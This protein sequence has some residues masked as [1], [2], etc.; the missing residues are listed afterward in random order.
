MTEPSSDLAVAVSIISSCL[1]EN[2]H[3]KTAFIGEIGM[4]LYFGLYY[5]LLC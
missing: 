4:F 3:M 2:I 5:L 1:E